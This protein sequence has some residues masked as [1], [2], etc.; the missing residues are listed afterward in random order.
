MTRSDLVDLEVH[1]HART[2]KAVLVSTDSVQERAVWVPLSQVE[3]EPHQNFQRV[4]V[5]TMPEW[6]ATEKGLV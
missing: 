2:A 6:L 3:I 5:L 1:V 4:F